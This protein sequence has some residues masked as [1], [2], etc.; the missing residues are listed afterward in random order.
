MC[1]EVPTPCT[2]RL[3]DT[4]VDTL[5]PLWK[6][7]LGSPYDSGSVPG[8]DTGTEPFNLS[9]TVSR[10]VSLG[11]VPIPPTPTR[12][13]DLGGHTTGNLDPK[14]LSYSDRPDLRPPTSY[15][16]PSEF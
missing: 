2:M 7:R 10:E 9:E 11:D 14:P 15:R 12:V 6:D 3:S 8:A 16:T 4:G 5:P 13:Q 1:V